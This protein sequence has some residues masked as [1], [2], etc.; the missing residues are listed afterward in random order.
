MQDQGT[1][2]QDGDASTAVEVRL[3][4]VPEVTQILSLSHGRVYELIRSGRLRSVR[5][6]RSRLVSTWAIAEYVKLLEA[7]ADA[8]QEAGSR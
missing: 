2:V 6:G 3:Y 4:K 5:E 7:E 8:G 1:P